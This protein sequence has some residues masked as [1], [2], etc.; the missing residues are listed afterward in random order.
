MRIIACKDIENITL[1]YY[2]MLQIYGII[3]ETLRLSVIKVNLQTIQKK[4]MQ[5]C[6]CATLKK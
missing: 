1:T 4:R 2:N 6:N 5:M 3:K